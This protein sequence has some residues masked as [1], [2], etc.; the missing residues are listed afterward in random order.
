MGGAVARVLSPAANVIDKVAG[1]NITGKNKPQ[2]QA[3]APASQGMDSPAVTSA[4]RGQEEMGAR[5]R[6]ARRR[7]RMLLSDSR[8]NPEAGVETLGGG[9]NLG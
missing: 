2:A 6:G 8:L 7:G 1:T 3:Q 4:T 9:N 5:L